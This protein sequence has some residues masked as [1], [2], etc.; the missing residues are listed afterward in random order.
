M[1]VVI[2]LMM[3][4]GTLTPNPI[5]KQVTHLPRIRK[6]KLLVKNI[7]MYPRTKMILVRINVGFR[8]KNSAAG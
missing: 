6:G 5:A 1:I 2:S 7:T 8:P 3:M 4:N